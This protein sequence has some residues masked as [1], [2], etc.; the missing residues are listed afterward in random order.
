MALSNRHVFGSVPGTPVIQPSN[1][2]GGSPGDRIA[3]V[4]R[5]GSLDAAIAAPLDSTV[6]SRSI[7]GGGAGIFEIADAVIG[8]GVQKTGRTT[9]L[10]HG[11][12]DL[13]DYDSGHNGSRVDLWIDG[14]DADFSGG[15][16]SGS[17]YLESDGADDPLDAH[18]IIGLH[19]GGSGRD[20]VGHPIRAVFDDLGVTTLAREP[21]E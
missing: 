18:R 8:M 15:G 9:G 1:D 10:T 2:D 21:V 3:S 7:A 19:W 11:V 6:V 16:D 13:I 14:G 4:V 17:L 5:A 12:V 20:G